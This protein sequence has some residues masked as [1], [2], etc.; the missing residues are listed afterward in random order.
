MDL[1]GVVDQPVL[2][3]NIPC[4]G[5]TFLKKSLFSMQKSAKRYENTIRNSYCLHESIRRLYTNNDAC[6]C[7]AD[8]QWQSPSEPADVIPWSDAACCYTAQNK[9]NH[10]VAADVFLLNLG[11]FLLSWVLLTTMLFNSFVLRL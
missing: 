11:Q 4:I 10:L 3:G 6:E 9:K 2:F 5:E 7:T 1:E 8:S